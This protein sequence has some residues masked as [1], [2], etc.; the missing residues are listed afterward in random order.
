MYAEKKGWHLR[1]VEVRLNHKNMSMKDCKESGTK[2]VTLEE[3][4]SQILLEGDLDEKMRNQLF[5]I[6]VRCPVHR[7][8]SSSLN[9]LSELI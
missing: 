4:R 2:S 1:N 5:E 6:A 7:T 9:I 3:I 8:L